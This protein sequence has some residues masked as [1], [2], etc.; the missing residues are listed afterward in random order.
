LGVGVYL[1]GRDTAPLC[2]LVAAPS[3]A[4]SQIVFEHAQGLAVAV[5]FRYNTL[6]VGAW[7][8]RSSAAGLPWDIKLAYFQSLIAAWAPYDHQYT[9][10]PGSSADPAAT[11]IYLYPGIWSIDEATG[12]VTPHPNPDLPDP[13]PSY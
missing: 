13:V 9:G 3:P 4:H 1:V 8:G 12:A 11:G 10:A 5:P 6:V 2:V 7:W